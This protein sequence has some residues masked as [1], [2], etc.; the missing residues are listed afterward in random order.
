MRHL[1]YMVGRY[2]LLQD[3][4]G[5]IEQ[6]DVG[7]AILCWRCHREPK[8]VQYR[9]EDTHGAAHTHSTAKFPPTVTFCPNFFGIANSRQR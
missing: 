8:A 6:W 3:K 2:F 7:A 1:K 9:L 4:R 5:T